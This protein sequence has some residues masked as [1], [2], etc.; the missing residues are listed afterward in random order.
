[1]SLPAPT[2]KPAKRRV[3][4]W[5]AALSIFAGL[6]VLG[7]LAL[8]RKTTQSES[9][10]AQSTRGGDIWDQSNDESNAINIGA[11]AADARV[12]NPLLL[13]QKAGGIGAP[14]AAAR[15][16]AEE[17]V[18][19]LPAATGG[20]AAVA[21]PS[22]VPRPFAAP[23]SALPVATAPPVPAAPPVAAAK[24]NIEQS[25]ADSLE[26]ARIVIAAGDIETTRAALSKLA[27]ELNAW[28]ALELGKTYDP[29]ILNALGVRDFPP[30]VAK[31][32]AW[33]QRAQLM[34]SPDAAGLLESLETSQ[35]RAR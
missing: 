30:D 15:V 12:G 27:N 31:A 21:Y 35:R 17:S 10:T 8:Y 28:A 3:F 1:L 2:H 18:A 34:G 23:L 7:G 19:F 25:K 16:R 32:R 6:C 26:R 14:G 4:T 13:E 11:P 24:K 5:S 33:Y 20:A 22:P 29:N 9:V